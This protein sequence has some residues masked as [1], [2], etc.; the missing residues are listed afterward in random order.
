M[1]KRIYLFESGT[2]KREDNN[3]VFIFSKGNN[4]IYLPIHQLECI[5][6]YGHCNL[7]K[8]ILSLLSEYK[9][10][11]FF[12]TFTGNYIGTF[13]GK[14]NQIG[15][16][17]IN[18]VC[19][20][21]NEQNKN[22][23]A[24]EIIYASMKNMIA[25]LK[26]YNKKGTQ[27]LSHIESIENILKIIYD[28][29]YKMLIYEARAKQIYYSAFNLIIKNKDFYFDKRSTNPPLD[30]INAIMSYGYSIL[31]GLIENDIYKSNLNISLPFIHGT[32]KRNTGLQYD[33]ADI[34]KPVIIDRLIFR[35]IN[36][37]QLSISHFDIMDNKV[38]LNKIGAKLFIMELEQTLE[39]IITLSNNKKISYR[40]II[41][42]EI[43]NI[44]NSIKKIQNIMH[45]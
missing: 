17:L 23:Y 8:E 27:L 26:Y 1:K 2:L 14:Y 7:N 22:I 40:S 11:I 43:H 19:C 21:T 35:L 25:I 6:I 39:S 5:Y 36:K 38:L 34:F 33:I 4:K 3:I 32:S 31:Y 30:P 16:I 13:H 29:P 45:F 20:I 9:I 41:K 37:K 42:R 24:L 10:I 28:E 12:Y 18:Q 44:E 15:A